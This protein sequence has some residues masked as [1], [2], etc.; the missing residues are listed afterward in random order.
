MGTLGQYLKNAREA[1]DVDLRDAAQQTRISVNYLKALEDEDFSKLP[2]EVFVRGFLKNYARFL[3]L[4]ETDVLRRYAELSPASAQAA[5]KAAS[6][7]AAGPETAAPDPALRER[8][9]TPLE[10]FIWGTLICIALLA[11]LFSSLPSKNAATGRTEQDHQGI[12]VISGIPQDAADVS[13]E[14]AE[15]LYLE[16]IALEDTWLLI[17]TDASPQKKAVL[18]K[19]ESLIWSAEER[20]LLSYG[21]AG[22]VK[23]LLNGEEVAVK[24]G[25]DAAIR[26]LAVTRSG[27]VNQPIAPKPPKPIVRKPRPRVVSAQT[28]TAV[29]APVHR[30]PKPPVDP[31]EAAAVPH[32]SGPAAAAHDETAAPAPGPDAS[33]SPVPESPAQ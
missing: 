10:P 16:V 24:G 17:R 18:K 15:K 33:D 30:K 28:S 8:S 14:R 5:A 3:D 29:P 25:S 32:N 4:E 9:E 19:G 22:D 11:F 21:R 2:G 6:P 26:D 20:F 23:L 31:T 1:K 12:A 7:T 13:Q 27:I